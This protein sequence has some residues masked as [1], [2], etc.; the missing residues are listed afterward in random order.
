MNIACIYATKTNHSK[1]I[2][3]SIAQ[4]LDIPA[5]DVRTHPDL[6]N[7][8]LLFVVGGIYGSQSLPVLLDYLHQ[9]EANSVKR[10]ALVTSSFSKGAPQGQVREILRQKGVSVFEEEC[11]CQGSFLFLKLGHPNAKE[12]DAAAAF[13]RKI[14]R[15]CKDQDSAS[16][17]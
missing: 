8:D 5:Q 10:A 17:V 9:L 7:V 15:A 3:E 4:T 13:A 1:K 11:F 14:R 2:A 12:R 16:S 6:Q